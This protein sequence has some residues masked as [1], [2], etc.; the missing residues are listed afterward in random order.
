MKKIFFACLMFLL[1]FTLSG[2]DNFKSGKFNENLTFKDQLTDKEKEELIKKVEEKW[3]NFVSINV[4]SKTR[5]KSNNEYYNEDYNYKYTAYSNSVIHIEK[6]EKIEYYEDGITFKEKE[7]RSENIWNYKEANSIISSYEIDNETLYSVEE[8]YSLP[9]ANDAGKRVDLY[10]LSSV[11]SMTE[12]MSIMDVYKTGKNEY[13]F[14]AS[15]KNEKYSAVAWG[16]GTKERHILQQDQVFFKVNGDGEIK[17]IM[18]YSAYITNQDPYTNEWYKSN[19][20]IQEES[21]TIKIKYGERKENK[22]L[23]NELNAAYK[24][25]LSS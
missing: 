11:Q 14:V 8:T 23:E 3:S 7:Q 17:N 22:E 5:D 6:T 21:I 9:E 20:K 2:C 19:K 13:T 24:A 15:Y 25:S 1:L 4:K 16:N 18:Y 10:I 12:F